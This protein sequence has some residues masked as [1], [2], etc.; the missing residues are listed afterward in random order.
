MNQEEE[1]GL[2]GILDILSEVYLI[3]FIYFACNL[4]MD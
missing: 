4:A 3:F 2:Q 1:K